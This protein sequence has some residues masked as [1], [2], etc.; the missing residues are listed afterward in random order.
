M[1]PYPRAVAGEPLSLTFDYRRGQMEFTFRHDPAV[2]AP[3]EIFVSNYA[4]P[5]GYA[6]EVSDGEYSVDRERQ[7]LS[8]HHIPDREVHHVRIIRP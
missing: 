8:Y 4:Y 3:T 7:T 2:A 6:V 1:R 5:D